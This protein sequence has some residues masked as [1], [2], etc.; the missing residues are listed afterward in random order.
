MTWKDAMTMVEEAVQQHP[1]VHQPVG[2]RRL[3]E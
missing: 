1:Q 3:P 2:C